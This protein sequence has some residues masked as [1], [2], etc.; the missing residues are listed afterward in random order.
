MFSQL[1][2]PLHRWEIANEMHRNPGSPSFLELLDTLDSSAE[3]WDV[4]LPQEKFLKHTGEKKYFW[5]STSGLSKF[6]QADKH[7]EE[8]SSTVG[9]Y[10]SKSGRAKGGE[11]SEEQGK[12]PH[13][14][15]LKK[16]IGEAATASRFLSLHNVLL[17]TNHSA[18][19]MLTKVLLLLVTSCRTTWPWQWPSL[20]L[21]RTL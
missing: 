12:F 5:T 13:S 19:P 1:I 17:F 15:Q 3:K 8:F 7:S 18:N 9:G 21:T 11:G 20:E 6:E 14:D 2:V 16:K 4:S 10:E